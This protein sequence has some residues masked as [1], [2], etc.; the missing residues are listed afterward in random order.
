MSE[1][2]LPNASTDLTGR[3]ALVTGGASGLGAED[4]RV[5]AREGASTGVGAGQMSRVV[6]VQIAVEKAGEQA[7]GS[8]LSSDAFFPFPDG[9]EEAAR[10]IQPRTAR[11]V[12]HLDGAAV[13]DVGSPVA[14]AQLPRHRRLGRGGDDVRVGPH[15]VHDAPG[16]G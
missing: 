9:I 5:L 15:P 6:S 13:D 12:Q 3:V 10:E 2:P 11:R 1:Y 7:K 14:V 8:V 4:A 16:A